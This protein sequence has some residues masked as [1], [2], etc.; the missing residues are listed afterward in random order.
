MDGKGNKM[1]KEKLK[2]EEKKLKQGG[3]RKTIARKMVLDILS[4]TKKHLSIQEIYQ[5]IY[6]KYPSIGMTTIYRTLELF[7]KLGI[8]SKYDFGDGRSRYELK[9]KQKEKKHHH[10]LI[11]VQCNKVVD[12][13]DFMDEEVKMIKK[14]EKAF[15]EKYKFEIKNHQIFFYGLCE[16]CRKNIEKKQ[17]G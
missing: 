3:Y 16:K 14:L 11:C 8:V 7:T 13:T 9:E 2:E 6:K 5:K 12:Y 10:H 1:K 17:K 4:R 15:S